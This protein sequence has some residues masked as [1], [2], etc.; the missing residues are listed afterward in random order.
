MTIE[1]A[2]LRPDLTPVVDPQAAK[3][4]WPHSILQERD[5]VSEW[6]AQ[7]LALE[8]AAEMG[9]SAQLHVDVFQLP[10]KQQQPPP[11]KCKKVQVCNEAQVLIAL[12]ESFEF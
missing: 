3:W 4:H 1:H 6:Q 11:A 10:V 5:F 7:S 8:L 12:H 9:C 2:R